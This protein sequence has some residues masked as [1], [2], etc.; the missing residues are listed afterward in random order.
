MLLSGMQTTMKVPAARGR[1][2][3]NLIKMNCANP[4]DSMMGELVNG[5]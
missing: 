1:G 2:I 5:K 3:E 4:I